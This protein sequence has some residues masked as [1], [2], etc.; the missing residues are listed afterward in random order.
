MAIQ[1]TNLSISLRDRMDA[2][3]A[4][5]GQG[6]NAYIETSSRQAEIAAM[7]AKSDEELAKLGITRDR[8]VHY[9]FRDLLW[10]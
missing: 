9:V 10:V 3:F 7:D 2:F 1:S 6:L 5:L 4:R 8:I